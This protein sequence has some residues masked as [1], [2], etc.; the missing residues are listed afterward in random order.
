[1]HSGHAPRCSHIYTA[2]HNVPSLYKLCTGQE[3]SIV[4][5]DYNYCTQGSHHQTLGSHRLGWSSHGPT[6][7][8]STAYAQ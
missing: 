3:H 2:A 7:G 4:Y 1:M 8:Y 5:T 6:G